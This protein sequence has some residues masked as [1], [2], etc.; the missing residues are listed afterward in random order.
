MGRE[1][2]GDREA[3]CTI[4]FNTGAQTAAQ[5]S[6]A[7]ANKVNIKGKIMRALQ[8]IDQYRKVKEGKREGSHGEVSS[9]SN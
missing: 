9:L 1:D 5:T 8:I 6:V 7:I 2:T 3:R 4:I